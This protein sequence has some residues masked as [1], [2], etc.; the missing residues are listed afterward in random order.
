MLGPF[1]YTLYDEEDREDGRGSDDSFDDKR[2][3]Q[4]E[5][6]KRKSGAE[7]RGELDTDNYRPDGKGFKVHNLRSVYEGYFKDGEFHGF[8]RAID[9][10][11]NCY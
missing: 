7:Y 6:E 10:K 4:T 11:G 9:A 5:F 3:W 8:G 1:D 2:M